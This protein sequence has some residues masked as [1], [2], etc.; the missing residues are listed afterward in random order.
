VEWTEIPNP[1]IP[2][3]LVVN[4][5]GV[6]PLIINKVSITI[7]YYYNKDKILFVVHVSYKIQVIEC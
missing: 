2:M 6:E 1:P 4:S 7:I 3:E 5:G